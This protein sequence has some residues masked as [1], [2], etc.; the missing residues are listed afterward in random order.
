MGVIIMNYC[1][2]TKP[3]FSCRKYI[4]L[5]TLTKAYQVILKTPIGDETIDCSEDT[6][7]LDAQRKLDSIYHI[8]VAPVPAHRVPE[9]LYLALSI[10][11]ISHFLTILRLETAS[12]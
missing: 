2:T 9:R 8:L 12:C 10:N 7:I 4:S 11:Q 3:A 6:Y 1:A 5:K